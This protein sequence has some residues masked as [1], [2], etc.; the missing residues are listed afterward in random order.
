MPRFSRGRQVPGRVLW[1]RLRPVPFD[2]AKL[3]PWAADVW[4]V[5]EDDPDVIR[6]AEAFRAARQEAAGA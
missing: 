6:W 2:R 4:P 1:L 3:E 5:A